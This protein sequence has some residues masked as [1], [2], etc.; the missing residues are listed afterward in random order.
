MKALLLSRGR[1]TRMRP[2]TYTRN[3]H[4][5]PIANKPLI[6]YPFEMIVNAGIKKLL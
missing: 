2:L 1:G 3:K 4:L 5:I 6:L